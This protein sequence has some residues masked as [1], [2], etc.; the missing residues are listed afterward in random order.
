MMHALGFYHEHSRS[1]RDMYIDIKWNNIDPSYHS[2]F[3]TYR[4]G[5]STHPTTASSQHTGRNI[6]PSYHSQFTTYR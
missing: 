1:D 6:D 4:Y 3:T 2:Q 5:T